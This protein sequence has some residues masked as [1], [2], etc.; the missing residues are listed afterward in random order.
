VFRASLIERC[1]TLCVNE[2]GVYGVIQ[3]FTPIF[4]YYSLGFYAHPA[5]A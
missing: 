3:N 1:A 2:W 4:T 5:N